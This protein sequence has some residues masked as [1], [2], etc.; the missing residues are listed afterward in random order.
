M[1]RVRVIVQARTSSARLAGKSL[2]PVAGYPAA[3][4]AALRASRGS[5]ETVLATSDHPS[6]DRLARL[7]A[8]A[9]I[10]VVRGPLDDVLERFTLA[11]GGLPDDAVV[12]RLTADNLL[13]DAALV[14]EIL[15]ELQHRGVPY[16]CTWSPELDV[17][18]GLSVEA[19]TAGALRRAARTAPP[20]DREHVTP[21]IRRTFGAARHR[22][23]GLPAGW[24][25]LS[26]TIDTLGD[27]L[28]VARA[29]DG[30]PDPVGT[31]WLEL[32]RRL[33]EGESLLPPAVPLV[34][35]PDGLHSR[36][37][38][39]TAQLGGPYGVTNQGRV[40]TDELASAIVHKAV[41]QGVTQFDTARAYG[42]SERRLGSALASAAQ[43]GLLRGGRNVRVITKL[44]PMDEVPD[45][46][47][48]R[49]LENAVDASVFRS[50]R[51]LGVKELSAVLVHRAADRRRWQGRVWRR[52]I[53][54]RRQGVIGALGVS[55]ATPEE[56]LDA[57]LDPDVRLLQIPFNLLDWRWKEYGIDAAAARRPD[58]S[59][60]TRSPLLQGL[61]TPGSAAFW[62]RVPGVDP[63]AVLDRLERAAKEFERESVLD[64]ALA[65]VRAHGWIHGV[66]VG[67]AGPDQVQE[68]ARLFRLSPLSP[69]QVALLDARGQRLPV[70]L[71]DPARW[72]R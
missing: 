66:V 5:W 44:L 2:L 45:E 30:A 25:R 62:P 43:R 56:A 10:R 38:V 54:L 42:E 50:C 47:P 28:R 3:V 12:V 60:H 40:P 36:L 41:A 48:A 67:L 55:A 27:Y 46:T 37:V 29:F 70:D 59:V 52:L 57:L 7:V 32:C 16:L 15:A 9:G 4:L 24:G 58:V 68:A 65:Y 22:P 8:A 19:F 18:L 39:G 6:D 34:S 69:E 31:S 61:L 23:R 64:L 35:T 53:A 17:P 26:C 11:A 33:A 71:L 49:W 20:G 14:D 21:W 1:P 13:P 63:R 72:P 51:E